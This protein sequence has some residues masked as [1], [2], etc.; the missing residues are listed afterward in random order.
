[1][2]LDIGLIGALHVER[3]GKRDVRTGE[4]LHHTLFQTSTIDALL[5]GSYEGDIT[6]AEL[7]AQGD[8]GL[9]TFDA[10][11]GEMVGLDGGFYQVKADG[12]AHEVDRLM[13]TPFAVVTF[14]KP[15][16]VRQIP[17]PM[18]YAAL[19]SSLDELVAGDAEACHAVRI[20]GHFR[21]VKTRSVPRQRKP[22]PPLAEAVKHQ[23]TFEL[24][25]IRGSLV[26]F[27]FPDYVGGLNV[28]GY[29]FHFITEDRST[30]GHLLEFQIASGQLSL[31]HESDLNLELPVG[32]G[33]AMPDLSTSKKDE[34]E[35]IEN[36]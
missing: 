27:R 17:A 29:H 36:A 10:L 22:Y 21:Y 24:H 15:R 9:G 18:D 20:D 19:R 16:E 28:S 14:F 6:F 35:H 3:V 8:F 12:R 1:M 30:G 32:V 26:G 7:E 13:K 4:H 5:D 25:D 33:E 11:D 23:P 31:D 2:P 34:L